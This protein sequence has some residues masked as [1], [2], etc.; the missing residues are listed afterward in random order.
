M[1]ENNP[2]ELFDLLDAGV[3][4]QKVSKAFSDV[5]LGVAIHG[6]KGRVL[7]TFDFDRIGESTQ[8]EM[9]HKVAFSKPTE[10]G[11]VGEENITSTPLHVGV[12][13]TLTVLETTGDL[14]KAREPK[15]TP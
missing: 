5:A 15:D 3:F 8:V 10:H 13:G 12:G 9:T 4:R 11:K 1:N 14:F 7:L 2:T 6:K